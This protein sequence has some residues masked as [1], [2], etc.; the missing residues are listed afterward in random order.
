MQT[1][2]MPACISNFHCIAG[3]C[4]DNCCHG[5]SVY[6]DKNTY[7]KYQDNKSKDLGD[8]LRK[9]TVRIDDETTDRQYAKY[10]MNVNGDCP[11]FNEQGLC[12]IQ[13]VLG[14]EMLPRTCI[15]YPHVVNSI[16][17]VL[18]ISAQL[19]CPVIAKAVMLSPKPMLF[20]DAKI[21]RQLLPN[22]AFNPSEHT[23]KPERFF[24]ELR[25]FGI[26][27][28]QNRNYSIPE[29][30][31]LLGVFYNQLSKNEDSYNIL[32]LIEIAKQQHANVNDTKQQLSPIQAVPSMQIQLLK[33]ISD[34]KTK[35]SSKKYQA[36][37]QDALQGL[38]FNEGLDEGNE[39][40][41]D[42]GAGKEI[43]ERQV[44]ENYLSGIELYV[45]P[46]F[47]EHGYILEHVLVHEFFLMM[48]PF[49]SFQTIWESYMYLMLLYGLIKFF[50]TGI[51]CKKGYLDVQT[52]QSIIQST[53]REIL[54]NEQLIKQIILI[55]QK[56]NLHTQAHMT[57]LALH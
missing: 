20:I 2:L 56:N 11:F 57:I 39:K 10:V 12:R 23:D 5:W 18:E 45:K 25:A 4:D 21:D 14:K 19:S 38:G 46:F 27:T 1:Y 24:Q 53:A 13:L 54:H 31:V 47:Y 9:K 55:F 41:T 52:V 29:R 44:L 17:G 51:A 32:N 7:Q 6:I 8:E 36:M 30:L 26:A 34:H 40:G 3:A 49:G 50:M 28:L 35:A 37:Y 48:M 22:K 42:E 15:N 33:L 43:D 16:D